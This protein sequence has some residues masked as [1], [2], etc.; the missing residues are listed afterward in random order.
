M[1]LNDF[2]KNNDKQKDIVDGKIWKINKTELFKERDLL[3][4]IISLY[5]SMRQLQ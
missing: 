3:K 4:I 2:S 1:V 5:N